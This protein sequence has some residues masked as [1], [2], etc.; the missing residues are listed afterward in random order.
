MNN[1][2]IFAL[3]FFDGVHLGHQALLSRC[4]ELARKEGCEAA[5]ITFDRHPKAL[6][7]KEPPVL[8]STPADRH[9][10]LKQYGMGYI[11]QFPVVPEVTGMPWRAFLDVLLEVAKE[12]EQ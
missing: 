5:A 1:K 12:Y 9:F 8:I 4:A 2:R 11:R 3:G 6:V 10:L 7:W